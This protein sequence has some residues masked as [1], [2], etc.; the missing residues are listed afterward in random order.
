M[1][2]QA[3]ILSDPI[4]SSLV[5]GGEDDSS[6][7]ATTTAA[8]ITS[9]AMDV[10]EDKHAFMFMV[11]VPG[12]KKEEV[13]VQLEDAEKGRKL[14][15]ISGERKREPRSE[16]EAYHRAERNFGKFHRRFGLPET[17][18]VAKIS[19]RCEDGVL[20]VTVPKKPKIEKKSE[21]TII[22]VQ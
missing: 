18:D 4:V 3:F 15:S 16:S 19:A 2:L 12:L 14:L 5:A 10:K 6:R 13:K 20:T 1:A 9:A 7:D 21:P 11:D 22:T 8:V 17:A